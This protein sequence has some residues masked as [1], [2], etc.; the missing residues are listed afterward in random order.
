LLRHRRNN[1]FAAGCALLGKN[2]AAEAV[3]DGPVQ[4]HH[5]GIHGLGDAG[6]T[7]V[8]QDAQVGEKLRRFERAPRRD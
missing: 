4:Q 8:D 1:L 2:F 3:A 5:A 6:P 7:R